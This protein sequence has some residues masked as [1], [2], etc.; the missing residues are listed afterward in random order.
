[1]D[2]HIM[3]TTISIASTAALGF[4]FV[5]LAVAGGWERAIFTGDSEPA[6]ASHLRCHYRSTSQYEFSIMF[7]GMCRGFVSVNPQTGQVKP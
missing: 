2:A 1:M 4:A 5:G 3:R 7:E 6:G